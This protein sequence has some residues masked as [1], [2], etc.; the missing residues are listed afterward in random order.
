MNSR[1]RI[2]STLVVLALLASLFT[3]AP[4]AGATGAVTSDKSHITT[5]TTGGQ[6]EIS[7][8][9]SDLE[10]G[11]VQTEEDID[12]YGV[13]YRVSRLDPGEVESFFVQKLPLLDNTDDG[14]VNRNDVTISPSDLS[15]RVFSVVPS[16]GRIDI[17]NDG[18]SPI[19]DEFTL[20]YNAAGFQ[21]HDVTVVSTRD[22]AG[23]TLT[24][25]EDAA[26]DGTYVAT[27]DTSEEVT[28][29]DDILQGTF[30]E[31]ELGVDLDGDG[32]MTGARIRI[33]G[34][35]EHPGTTNEALLVNAYDVAI[36]LDLDGDGSAA[37][38]IFPTTTFSEVAAGVDLNDDGDATDVGLTAI[39]VFANT[40]NEEVAG[41]DF[42]G[43]TFVETVGVDLDG[44]GFATGAFAYK[45]DVGGLPQSLIRPKIGAQAGDQITVTYDDDGTPRTV[46]ITVEVNK[47]LVKI[48]SPADGHATQAIATT[49]IDIEVTD[50]DAG[51]DRDDI[52]NVV[53]VRVS[54]TDSAITI[55]FV[56]GSDVAINAGFTAKYRI[57]HVAEGERKV[58][59]AFRVTD[60]AGNVGVSD[61]DADTDGDQAYTV[62]FDTLTPGFSAATADHG[63]AAETGHFWDAAADTPGLNNDPANA[64]DTSIAV[65]F[66]ED[67]D[68]SSV[69]RLDFTVGGTAPAAANWFA[70]EP[71]VVFLTVP[72]MAPDATP[73]VAVVGAV[74]DKAG[75]PVTAIAG[76]AATDGIGPTI[77]VTITPSTQLHKDT[78]TIDIGSNEKFLTS[79]IV[80]ANGASA[81]LSTVASA[82][83]NLFRTTFTAA[84]TNAYNIEVT[85]QDSASNQVTTGATVHDGT[86]AVVVEID[87]ALPAPVT[88]PIDAENTTAFTGSPLFVEINYADEGAE[89]GLDVAGG[90]LS[91]TT[92]N[93]VV[94][95]DT[96]AG[97][98]VTAITLDDVDVSGQLNQEGDARYIVALG[99]L[100]VS[101]ADTTYSLKFTGQDDAGNT[102]DTEVTFTVEV[103]PDFSI[104]L[105]TGWNLISLS[106]GLGAGQSGINTVIPATHDIDV[107]LTYDPTDSRRWLTATRGD[108]GLFDT[109]EISD[110]QVNL[111]YF[112]RTTSFDSLDVS[113]P[114]VRGGEASV[115][116]TI[117]LVQGWNL[118]PV[119]DVT[120]DKVAGAADAIAFGTYF[121]TVSDQRVY[122][123]NTLQDKFEIAATVEVAKGYWVWLD[124]A[125]TLVP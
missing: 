94:D 123:Y 50:A 19:T 78:V 55:E 59:Y 28:S 83:T 110:L 119:L 11:Q 98:A 70:G 31:A 5:P 74:A 10:A 41:L 15:L 4:V 89:Y 100:A 114:G 66:D 107:V 24:L 9:D 58:T 87:N 35:L 37:T 14:I 23:F 76:V 93:I 113:V 30:S 56:A 48:L 72:T 18:D 60:K 63:R 12:A 42:T 62:R 92:D 27:F 29:T 96:H 115:L 97:V 2:I 68:G 86:D 39:I 16:D 46:G 99:E 104:P 122:G 117:S 52:A 85:S 108:D 84:T 79:P 65:Y 109:S 106:G 25:R 17:Q 91:T 71:D 21:S 105:T 45:I 61:S 124:A 88:L 13:P 43:D 118:V 36:G 44:D 116:P 103:R 121:G 77:T 69:G 6:V 57:R 80:T 111:A 81:G 95:L 112:V 67:L 40:V 32:T 33:G 51:V 47:P 101:P 34:P 64:D 26:T 53:D 49:D 20:T 73:A 8:D 90:A 82:G 22:S 3:V 54:S 120:G 38:P 102:L 75:N 125:G 7:L 1:V